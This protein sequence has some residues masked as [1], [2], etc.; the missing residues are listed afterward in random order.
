MGV[1]A[2]LGKKCRPRMRLSRV[3]LLGGV[4]L[5]CVILGSTG[6]ILWR[7]RTAELAEWER[8]LSNWSLMVSEHTS[9]TVRAADLVLKGITDRVEDMELATPFAV[10]HAMASREVHDML[11]SANQSAPQVD[12]AAIVSLT[13]DLINFS[14]SYPPPPINLA[15]RDY[16]KAHM[17]D[18]ALDVFISRPVQNRGTGRWTFYLARKIRGRNGS[19][20]GLALAGIES[21]FFQN[22]YAATSLGDEF[23][24]SLL[25]RDGILLARDPARDTMLGMSFSDTPPF[26]SYLANGSF[27]TVVTTEP[28]KADGGARWMRILA[29]HAIRD[30]PLVVNVTATGDLVLA[31]WWRGV[32]VMAFGACALTATLGGLVLWVSR[33]LARRERGEIELQ[34]SYQSLHALAEIAALPSGAVDKITAALRLGAQHLCL[35]QA[36]V[37]RIEEERYTVL[38]HWSGTESALGNGT[39]L[40]LGKT[41]CAITLAA[42][43]VVAIPDMT[44]SSYAGHPCHQEFRLECYIGVPITVR[45]TVCGTVAFSSALPYERSFDEGDLEFMR[46]LGRWVGTVLEERQMTVDLH[47]L[48]TSDPLTGVPNRREFMAFAEQHLA[49]ALR[50]DRPMAVL[51]LDVDNFKNVN[52]VY[53]HAMGD[54]VLIAV[55]SVCRT[56]LRGGDMLGRMGGEEFAVVLPDASPAVAREVAERLRTTV[57]AMA[58]GSDGDSIRVTMSLGV[59]VR[60]AGDTSVDALLRRADAA[61]YRAKATGRNRVVGAAGLHEM[62]AP[63]TRSDVARHLLDDRG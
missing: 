47:R 5:A 21:S 22:F 54:E 29:T 1:R 36:V 30:Y 43:D 31:R 17:K 24:V 10:Q 23:S 44:K 28:R 16:F 60:Q 55:A 40:D 12:V 25:R 11:K 33:L 62:S 63:D 14:R 57:E 15:D 34:R 53:G 20:L 4:A 7:A 50:L 13:G 19:T 48:A 49:R 38:H 46:L 41:Y 56:V 42:D 26:R 6:A 32:A 18:E 51:M 3:V 35:D 59:A 8:N 9:Q 52:D 61:L 2:A 39:V 58:V 37:S 45:G 27:G